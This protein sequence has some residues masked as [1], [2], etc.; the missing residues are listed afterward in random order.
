MFYNP[1][2]NVP[3]MA[4]FIAWLET[5]DPRQKYDFKDCQGGCLIGQYMSEKGIP[6]GETPNKPQAHW[7]GT[8]YNKVARAIFG[9]GV[10][11]TPIIERPW[12]FGAA[13]KR[14]HKFAAEAN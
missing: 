5:K 13:L 4:N 10:V 6:W 3:S 14:T 7:G 1:K 11:L 12:T 8:A 9:R 2:W